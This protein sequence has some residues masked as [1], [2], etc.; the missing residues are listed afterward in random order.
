[1]VNALEELHTL[2][3]DGVIGLGFNSLSTHKPNIMENLYHQKI[4]ENCTFS[5]FLSW[6]KDDRDEPL[7]EIILGGYDTNYMA[8]DNFYYTPVIDPRQWSIKLQKLKINNK[9]FKL[10]RNNIALIDSGTSLLKLP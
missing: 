2:E 8:E 1:M 7:S 9:T 10:Y 5:F 4:I 3:A 6:K